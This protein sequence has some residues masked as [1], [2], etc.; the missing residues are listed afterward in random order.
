MRKKRPEGI[1]PVMEGA[2]SEAGSV[3]AEFRASEPRKQPVR[4]ARLTTKRHMVTKPV[5]VTAVPDFLTGYF[6]EGETNVCFERT[7]HCLNA[8][9]VPNNSNCQQASNHTALVTETMGQRYYREF[10]WGSLPAPLSARKRKLR[11]SSRGREVSSAI[12]RE[13]TEFYQLHLKSEG[14]SS[15]NITSPAPPMSVVGPGLR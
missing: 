7:F 4:R 11:G 13:L 6:Y 10:L 15:R 3:V 9:P 14:G 2:G 12:I 1:S 5:L 8:L